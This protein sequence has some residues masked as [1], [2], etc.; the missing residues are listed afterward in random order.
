MSP[1]RMFLTFLRRLMFVMLAFSVLWIV[2]IFPSA[3]FLS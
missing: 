1:E 2:F 3:E